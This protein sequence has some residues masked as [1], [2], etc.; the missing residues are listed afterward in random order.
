[1]NERIL[2]A[3]NNKQTL[4]EKYPEEI[5]FFAGYRPGGWQSGGGQILLDKMI[6][7]AEADPEYKIKLESWIQKGK[8]IALRELACPWGSYFSDLT[9]TN[10]IDQLDSAHLA[11]SQKEN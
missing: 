6:A 1:M 8:T 7:K 9:H 4:Y 3:Y 10:A 11:F 2:S 5:T